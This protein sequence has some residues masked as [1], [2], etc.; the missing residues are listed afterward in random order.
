MTP[1]A[2]SIDG[3]PILVNLVPIQSIQYSYEAT[4]H[5]AT[6]IAHALR[7]LLTHSDPSLWSGSAADAFVRH[8]EELPKLVDKVSRSY[9]DAAYALA[10]LASAVVELDPRRRAATYGLEF[11]R[12]TASNARSAAQAAPN[13]AALAEADQQAQVALRRRQ[14]TANDIHSE[15]LFA[16]A[17]CINALELARNEAIPPLTWWQNAIRVAAR[18]VSVAIKVVA[19][20]ATV[21]AAICV[22][23]LVCASPTVLL[24]LAAAQGAILSATTAA[25]TTLGLA[26]LG[27][28]VLDRTTI[29][30]ERS[31][32]YGQLATE[33]AFTF[34]PSIA[35]KHLLRHSGG[36]IARFNVAR[37]GVRFQRTATPIIALRY[38]ATAVSNPGERYIALAALTGMPTRAMRALRIQDDIEQMVSR[39]FP[40]AIA[41]LLARHKDIV[42]VVALAQAAPG[43]TGFCI[44]IPN[45]SIRNQSIPDREKQQ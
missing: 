26:Y 44:S 33:T 2:S 22:V 45:N 1:Q 39:D 36:I 43:V 38:S 11:E 4:E 13:D 29:N 17:R 35:G 30:D 21:F 42:A 41:K 32:K 31:P 23:A 14:S 15:Y 8:C 20:I 37:T 3:V 24:L 19:V 16:E 10:T 27:L 12:V 7:S 5:N 34:G 40:D 28:R 18:I 6:E 25:A 9:H